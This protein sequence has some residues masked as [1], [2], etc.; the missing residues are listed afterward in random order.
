[1]INRLQ[2][3]T[4][5]QAYDQWVKQHAHGT[6]WQSLEWK[7]FREACG[8]EVRI[9]GKVGEA[10]ALVVIDKT[11]LGLSTWEISR[12]P[13]VSGQRTTDNGQ[14]FEQMISDANTEKCMSLFLSPEETVRCP[15][16]TVRSGRHIHPEAT[17]IVDLRLPEAEILAQMHEK[18]RYNIKVAQK[19]N[20]IISES[21]DIDAYYTL[22]DQT[23][24]RDGFKILPKKSYENF[25]KHL[26]GSF[27]ML[28]SM[29]D[30]K[31]IAGILG[32][33]WNGTGIYYYGASSSEHRNVMAPY[34]LQWEAMKKC[35]ALGCHS[36]DLLGVAP[37]DAKP[38]H[39]WQGISSF[40]A[41]FGG[42]LISYPP[43]R[44]LVLKP[45]M[46][47]L[48]GLKRKILG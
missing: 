29:P 6:L 12:G 28:A 20:V 8:K 13:L 23:G 26:P 47:T 37:E 33:S 38:N 24:G 45:V 18:G 19:H 41:K 30:G 2:S 46:K 21:Q 9:Y 42:Q 10:T 1:M 36:Y 14:L 22:A 32:V 27:L 39:P 31:V 5:L 15:L 48:L 35:K 4:E 44:E 34:L 11:S 40:K 17:R 3:P 16:S 43:E 25:V 7:T